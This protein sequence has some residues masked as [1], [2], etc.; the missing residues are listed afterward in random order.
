M[1]KPIFPQANNLDRIID[2][3]SIKLKGDD[4]T[5]S[6]ISFMYNIT[7]RQ[8]NYYLG[9]IDYFDFINAINKQYPD[10]LDN[11][12]TQNIKFYAY[13]VILNDKIFSKSFFAY[14]FNL[15]SDY[16]SFISKLI[17]KEYSHYSEE[18]L[19]RRAQTVFKWIRVIKD[20][21]LDLNIKKD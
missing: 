15:E 1:K 9:A 2:I 4:L 12:S 5:S 16:I 21:L 10:K 3:L 17:K 20:D 14:V 19:K 18:V 7:E 8:G 13:A 11:L 6:D